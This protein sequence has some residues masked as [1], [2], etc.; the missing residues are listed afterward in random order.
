M[1][2][3]GMEVNYG[4][5][6]QGA[7]ELNT[8]SQQINSDLESMDAELKPTQSEW[9]GDANQQY[10]AAKAEWTQSL[11]DMNQ[12]LVQLGAHVTTSSGNYSTADSQSAA[13]FGGWGGRGPSWCGPRLGLAGANIPL[14]YGRT[15]HHVD[16]R[17]PP[18]RPGGKRHTPAPWPV[19]P[20]GRLNS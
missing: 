20:A 12:V 1:S 5:M 17:D 16:E 6:D 11:Q 4:Q 7:Q 2:D 13:G 8:G 19:C 15:R 3:V 9:T 18:A 10:L 14:W